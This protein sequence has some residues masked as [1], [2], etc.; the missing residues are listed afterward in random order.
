MAFT[1]N[2]GGLLPASPSY[3]TWGNFSCPEPVTDLWLDGGTGEV[4]HWD[5]SEGWEFHRI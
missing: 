1:G 2:Q 4:Y 3:F 5:R